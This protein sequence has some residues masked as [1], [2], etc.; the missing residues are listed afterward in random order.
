MGIIRDPAEN[1]P[2]IQIPRE[3]H[4]LVA[5]RIDREHEEKSFELERAARPSHAVI[6]ER[7]PGFASTTRGAGLDERMLTA[8]G[9]SD[10]ALRCHSTASCRRRP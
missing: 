9:S 2:W 8:Y 4:A 7:P 10:R 6:T 3:N 5:F 1:E